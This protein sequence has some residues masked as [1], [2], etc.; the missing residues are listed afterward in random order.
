MRE[1][2]HWSGTGTVTVAESAGGTLATVDP[3]ANRMNTRTH[4]N[5]RTVTNECPARD[6]DQ[7][8]I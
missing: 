8:A 3:Q 1:I 6:I 5:P 4:S 2:E 7:P